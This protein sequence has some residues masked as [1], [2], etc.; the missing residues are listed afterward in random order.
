MVPV[1]VACSHEKKRN[2]LKSQQDERNLF[3]S[4]IIID[5]LP[6]RLIIIMVNNIVFYLVVQFALLFWFCKSRFGH[7]I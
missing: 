4:F 1:L 6:G 5:I 3:K 2:D 7:N